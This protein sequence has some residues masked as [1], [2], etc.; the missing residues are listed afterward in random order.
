MTENDDK[1]VYASE[2]P[3]VDEL[4]DEYKRC[5]PYA[6]GWDK[7]KDNDD[8]RFARWANQ[9]DDGKKKSSED[10]EAFPW[11]GASDTREFLADRVITENVALMVVAWLRSV[12]V[13][14]GVEAQDQEEA[15]NYTKLL[16]W[17]MGT[18]MSHELLREAQLSAQYREHYGNFLL[19]VTWERELANK[20]RKFTFAQLEEL[21]AQAP[22]TP[23][24]LLPALI[25]NPET[26]DEAVAM[27]QEIATAIVKGAFQE[28][29]KDTSD[30]LDTY[31]LKPK[32]ARKLVRQLRESGAG[33]IPLPYLCKNQPRIRTLKLW[34][35]VF[36]SQDANDI[37]NA[38]IFVRDYYSETQLKSIAKAQ[39]W[40]E[41][42]VEQAVKQKGK[43]ST[44][45]A[46]NEGGGTSISSQFT[47]TEASKT[48]NNDIEV[49]TCYQKQL[50][51]DDITT[52]NF[53]VFHADISKDERGQGESYATHGSLN[54][55]HDQL[56]FVDGCRERW[57]RS[58]LSSRGVPEL[59]ESRQREVKIQKDA[60]VDYTSINLIPPVNIYTNAMGGL[61]KFGPA[62]R[63]MVQPGRAPEFMDMKGRGEPVA[64]E[65]W[66]RMRDE[67]DLEFGYLSEKVPPPRA[68]MKQQMLVLNYLM[69]WSEA[70][71]QVFA[72]CQ[73]FMPD[74]LYMEITGSEKPLPKGDAISLQKD[75]ILEFDVR[76]LDMEHVKAQFKSITEV[77]PFDRGGVVDTDRLVRAMARAINPSLAKEIIQE[78]EGAAMKV[79]EK[80]QDDFLKMLNG[81]Q[82]TPTMDDNPTAKME[83]E[84]AEQMVQGNPKV[85]Q[86]MQSDPM[87]QELLK[88][89][90]T[91]KQHNLSQQDNK[92]RGRTGV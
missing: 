36:V 31:K 29:V 24:S 41:S 51:D 80:V 25:M 20:L 35:D 84:I 8:V 68:Q 40:S 64:F 92:T 39:S 6:W 74:S 65:L 75:F 1:L 48:G 30:A 21:A 72:L 49:I 62:V 56:P 46:T 81:M 10:V 58:I 55:E 90:V 78:P 69:T 7:V 11:E 91:N 88:N 73:Q 52:I 4:I 42:W 27:L 87:F 5:T 60:L 86:A 82:P 54:Y 89:Y 77:L 17:L 45:T 70:F 71:R 22:G 33:E 67:V 26:E 63:N 85:Q 19:Q 47:W 3:K 50:D 18:K 23:I 61:Y 79:A 12:A 44:W 34:E 28:Q 15:A 66:D 38:R 32:R 16:E 13:A 9:S 57:H 76:Q 53:T 14:R 37:Q 59:V 43:Q 2:V 83:L